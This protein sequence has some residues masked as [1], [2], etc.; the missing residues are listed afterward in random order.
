MRP[1][2][3]KQSSI[4][5]LPT[6]PLARR[7]S[8]VL[9]CAARVAKALSGTGHCLSALHQTAVQNR[10]PAHPPARPQH[11]QDISDEMRAVIRALKPHGDK[12]RVVLNKADQVGGGVGPRAF[13]SS[14][15]GLVP[16]P[17]G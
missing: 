17:G 13:C 15:R 1:L 3:T 10:P 16:M 8:S 7:G 5:P 11:A 4:P 9:L 2:L 14:H 12:I 6:A